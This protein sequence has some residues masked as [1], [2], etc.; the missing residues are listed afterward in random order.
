[1]PTDFI[2]EMNGRRW[3][4]RFSP[5]RNMGT[6]WG[7]CWDKDKAARTGLIEI[8]RSLRGLRMLEVILH[9][10]LHA[11]APFLDEPAC[12][13]IAADLARSA[14]RSGYRITSR[15]STRSPGGPSGSADERPSR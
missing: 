15:P 13:R 11:S 2:V 12:D 14:W 1:M 7:R 5:P 8:R 9:E 10:A 4:F 3:T 6:D